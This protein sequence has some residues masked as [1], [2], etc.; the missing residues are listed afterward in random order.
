MV[1]EAYARKVES[2]KK[3]LICKAW[4]S[5]VAIDGKKKAPAV[6]AVNPLTLLERQQ[7]RLAFKRREYFSLNRFIPSLKR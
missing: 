4:F 7:Y 1:L 5:F 6:P 2:G 3:H